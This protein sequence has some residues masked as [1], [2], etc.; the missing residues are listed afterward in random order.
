MSDQDP[1]VRSSLAFF[2][3]AFWKLPW[4]RRWALLKQLPALLRHSAPN[5]PAE[6]CVFDKLEDYPAHYSRLAA[7]VGCSEKMPP[8]GE[9]DFLLRILQRPAQYYGA[10]GVSDVQFLTAFIGI[11]APRRVIE[12]GTSTGFSA[13]I[14]AGALS[15]QHSNDAGAAFVDT[16][17]FRRQ[18]MIDETQPTGFEIPTLVPELARMIRLHVPH[19]SSFVRELVQPNELPIIFIDADHRHPRVLL[20]V[21]RVAPYVRNGG[22]I[23]LHDVELGTIGETLREAGKP[24]P[25]GTP[26][27]AQWL[28]DRWPWRKIGGGNIGAVQVPDDR[29]ALV[30]FALRLMSVPFEIEGKTA[31]RTCAAL[32]Q[33]LGELA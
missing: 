2:W 17:D 29:R 19:D 26:Y 20:D 18:C 28:F 27:G 10:I 33:S 8:S 5:S 25:W 7:L 1:R 23:V 6:R 32:Y 13:I 21:L 11:L 30:P 9:V 31:T 12:I 24:T 14:I 16:V 22:W 3:S 4:N 15:R